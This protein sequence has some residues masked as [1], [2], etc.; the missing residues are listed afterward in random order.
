MLEN[1]TSVPSI[2]PALSFLIPAIL[3]PFAWL[4][5]RVRQTFAEVIAV[6]GAVAAFICVLNMVPYAVNGAVL[7]CWGQELRVDALSCLVVGLISLVG[8]ITAVY[9]IRY[10][11]HQQIFSPSGTNITARRIPIYYGLFLFFIATMMWGATT[12]NIIMLYVA[13]EATTIASGLLVAFMWDKR[14]LEAGYKYLMLLTVSITFAL[15][16]A[17]LL[18]SSAA[19]LLGGSESGVNAMLITEIRGIATYIPPGV[20][21]FITA[22]FIIGFG[23]KAGIAPFHP[24]LPDAHAEA[25]SPI[26]ALLSGVMIKMAV[27]ALARTLSIFFPLFSALS[28]FIVI[29]GCFTMLLGITMALVQ[30]D[31]KR[32]LA[33]SS[34]SQMGY[35]LMGI[36]F[37]TQLG[38]YGG[39]FHIVTHA[40]A[41]ALLFLAA[42]IIVYQTSAR[43]LSDLGG[44]AAKMPLTAILFFIGALSIAGLP[45]FGGFMSKLTIFMAGAQKHEWWAAGIGIFTSLLTL[46]VLLRA[47]YMIFW[48]E[49]RKEEVFAKAKE[50]PGAL[51]VPAGI[52]SVG[53]LLL[54]VWPNALYPWLQHAVRSLMGA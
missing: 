32:M 18:Y 8:V 2:W 54:G 17:V 33:Y 51:L 52:L 27:Y 23:T 44:L 29:L 43:R 11:R 38:V 39:L 40:F 20:A 16:G 41:K 26:S 34:V 13:V 21:I 5:G 31:I 47:G 1:V 3:A 45:P 25:P 53:C 28:L 22:L 42:G 36:G 46:I 12:N 19:S 15:F 6:I 24:W 49:P 9:S 10:M 37:W 4:L 30:N 14:A 7:S 50:A 35:V 48:G